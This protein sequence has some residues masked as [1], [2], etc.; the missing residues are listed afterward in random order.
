MKIMGKMKYIYQL[1][2][3]ENISELSLFVGSERAREMINKH[4]KQYTLNKEEK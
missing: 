2:Q 1:V 4:K 3:E